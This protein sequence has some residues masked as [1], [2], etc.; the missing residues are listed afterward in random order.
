MI[1]KILLILAICSILM[2][3]GCAR[4]DLITIRLTNDNLSQNIDALVKLSVV[5]EQYPQY[6]FLVNTADDAYEVIVRF[7][8]K[9]RDSAITF[10]EQLIKEKTIEGKIGETAVYSGE[11]IAYICRSTECSSPITDGSEDEVG[12]QQ[13]DTNWSC[14]FHFSI[15]ISP[16][17]AKRTSEATQNL[18]VVNKDGKEYLEKDLALYIDG[19]LIESFLLGAELKGKE[20]QEIGITGSA[21]GRTESEAK[22]ASL[23]KMMFLQNSLTVFPAKIEIKK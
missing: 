3:Q 9:D 22:K 12:C 2:I 21:T 11:D 10:F 4:T 13:A 20:I 19:N 14:P 5:L 16:E 18:S 23:D 8:P 17:A 15:Q 6:P 1:K 7:S